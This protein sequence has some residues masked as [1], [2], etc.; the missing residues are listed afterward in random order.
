VS[1]TRDASQS[2][3]A[4]TLSRHEMKVEHQ[5]ARKVTHLQTP[6]NSRV[7]EMSRN[8]IFYKSVFR[9]SLAQYKTA[10]EG[11]TTTDD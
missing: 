6:A 3:T 5:E 11:K 8:E 9:R 2:R 4:W 10:K 1:E 7:L